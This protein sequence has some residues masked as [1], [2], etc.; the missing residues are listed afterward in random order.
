MRFNVW[1]TDVD[2]GRKISTTSERTSVA[3]FVQ[4]GVAKLIIEESDQSGTRRV[5]ETTPAKI[6]FVDDPDV[7]AE[8]LIYWVETNGRFHWYKVLAKNPPC[9]TEVMWVC[10]A[11]E[12]R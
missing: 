5:T 9:G 7:N 11:E 3:C 12:N 1:T 6:Y 10:E 8:D 2:G 4:P